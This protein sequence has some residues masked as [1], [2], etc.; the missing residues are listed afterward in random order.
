MTHC[1]TSTYQT[2]ELQTCVFYELVAGKRPISV[3]C[4]TSEVLAFMDIPV[5]S[6]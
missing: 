1:S 6:W 5:T 3:I 2:V 4:E